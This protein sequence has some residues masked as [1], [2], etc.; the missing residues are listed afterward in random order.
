MRAT[1]SVFFSS[2]CM[3]SHVII[4]YSGKKKTLLDCA[5]TFEP[6]LHENLHT[7]KLAVPKAPL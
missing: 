2:A 4:P 5:S 6:G 7:F 3:K 1:D